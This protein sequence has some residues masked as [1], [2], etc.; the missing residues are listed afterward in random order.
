[1]VV[2]DGGSTR[3]PSFLGRILRGR[4]F[5]NFFMDLEKCQKRRDE[6]SFPSCIM[7]ILSEESMCVWE[8]RLRCIWSRLL[9]RSCVCIQRDEEV[10]AFTVL[11]SS[12]PLLL[13]EERNLNTKFRCV[14]FPR[15]LK[16]KR[17]IHREKLIWRKRRARE[18]ER[19]A[20]TGAEWV[21]FRDVKILLSGRQQH[22]IQ[23]Q[24]GRWKDEMIL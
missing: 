7:S 20:A 6:F 11:P 24:L 21:Y 8:L 9:W 18:R 12:R 19:V 4:R 16:M 22:I 23:T 14:N 1:M 3:R 2:T 5:W 10:K 15:I 17:E 13:L